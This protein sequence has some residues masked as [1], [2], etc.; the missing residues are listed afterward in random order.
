[1]E[2]HVQLCLDVGS[3]PAALLLL[4]LMLLLLLLLLHLVVM[5]HTMVQR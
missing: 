2:N 1:M 4:R 5:A 3:A